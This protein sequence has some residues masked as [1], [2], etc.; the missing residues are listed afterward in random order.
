MSKVSE[1]IPSLPLKEE[2]T[3]MNENVTKAPPVPKPRQRTKASTSAN[4]SSPSPRFFQNTPMEYSNIPGVY[5]PQK[6]S[7]FETITE[8]TTPDNQ[9]STAPMSPIRCSKCKCHLNDAGQCPYCSPHSENTHPLSDPLGPS[10]RPIP[11]P[12]KR[13]KI[14]KVNS[15]ETTSPVVA[16][17]NEPPLFEQTDI[18]YLGSPDIPN[19]GNSITPSGP[20][21][22]PSDT[23]IA[24]QKEP[25]N[26]GQSY[27]SQ[28]SSH[29]SSGEKIVEDKEEKDVLDA[30]KKMHFKYSMEIEHFRQL[31]VEGQRQYLDDKRRSNDPITHL[32]PY[33][34]GND[35]HTRESSK[36]MEWFSSLTPE[37]QQE[38]LD[39]R[40][41]KGES[42]DHL[43][44]L[45]KEQ[46]VFQGLSELEQKQQR[47]Q[48]LKDDGQYF[49][50]WLKV[51]Y[52][53]LYS[54]I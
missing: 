12:R 30:Y 2:P 53:V 26:T 4:L 17:P 7:N 5:I 50:Y 33:Y 15:N 46:H 3:V 52:S 29:G 13:T 8:E 21:M 16:Q 38:E 49:I 20:T 41:Q 19:V 39:L 18:S 45:I 54:T 36:D 23:G 11:K 43:S 44:F 10:S 1:T 37:K 25:S 28:D 27:Y 34:N 31:S 35:L 42:V 24:S 32:T 40:R 51:P 6:P 14:H 22:S 48:K 9:D 47:Q